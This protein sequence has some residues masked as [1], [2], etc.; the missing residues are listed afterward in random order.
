MSVADRN[1]YP[2]LRP[3]RSSEAPYYIGRELALRRLD[4]HVRLAPMT[5]LFARSGMGK[6][7]F[8][9]CRALPHFQVTGIVSYLNEWGSAPADVLVRQRLDALASQ[10][11]SDEL[12]LLVL[13]QFEDVFKLAAPLRPL[14]RLLSEAIQGDAP[15]ARVLV[16]MREEW[17]GAWWEAGEEIA[18]AT[19]SM[20]RLGPLGQRELLDAVT[21]P[22]GK[23]GSVTVDPALG[24]ILIA[25]LRQTNLYGPGEYVEPG[26]VQLVCRHLWEAARTGGGVMNQQLYRAMGG[27]DRIIERHLWSLLGRPLAKGG[28]F[29]PADRVLWCGLARHLVAARGIKSVLSSLELGSMLRYED[30]GL[31]GRVAITM[32]T[33]RETRRYLDTLPEHRTTRVPAALVTWIG[34]VLERATGADLVK[35][36]STVLT[37]P[38]G[39]SPTAGQTTGDERFELAH[40]AL[41]DMVLRF[42]AELE[43][44]L[45]KKDRQLRSA[46]LGVFIVA[47]IAVPTVPMAINHFKSSPEG[48]AEKIGFV[49]GVA[50]FMTAVPVL[51]WL[52]RVLRERGR[53]YKVR[54]MLGC[55]VP[56]PTRRIAAAVQPLP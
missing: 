55:S 24:E 31:A 38:G 37:A 17:L 13:D 22:G 42:G 12:P 30:L 21:A 19:D 8:L 10:E 45:Q 4:Q 6:S 11:S 7:S 47:L 18:C 26:L 15:Q 20:I 33:N 53:H 23:E 3:F 41:A 35:K 32:R 56:L 14:W 46:V 50:L 48:T 43:A 28:V 25:D 51:W 2:G 34:E 44:H 36:Q 16:S 49:I 27:T 9:T 5:V 29:A 54:W 40:D 1:P 52:S 39:M